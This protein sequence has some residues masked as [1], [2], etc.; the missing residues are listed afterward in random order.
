MTSNTV[1]HGLLAGCLALACCV[2]MAR[3]E[4]EAGFTPLFNGK[5]LTGWIGDTKG[6]VAEEG[7]IVCRPGG[8]LY[9]EKQYDNFV[10]RFEFKLTAGANNGLGIRTP[11]KGDAA[12]VGM[13]LQILDDTSEKYKN[14]AP[15]QAHGSIYGLVPSKRGHLKPVGEW[16]TQEVT[17]DGSKIKV[18]LN[19]VVIV[20]AD[21]STLEETPNIHKFEKHPGMKN[22]TG[23]IGFLGHG[24]VVEFRNLR[25]K[26]IAPAN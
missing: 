7:K 16:N 15:W 22:T 5:D 11:P 9:T 24:S 18:V 25:L 10:L 12:Y 13:E 14:I 19:G 17:A 26:P 3:A 1:K 20:D 2:Q 21:L 4:D 6:Y 23:H 8:N